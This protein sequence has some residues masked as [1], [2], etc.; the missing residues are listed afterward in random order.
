MRQ[1]IEQNEILFIGT[2]VF[3][4]IPIQSSEWMFQQNRA[5][6]GITVI[7]QMMKTGIVDINSFRMAKDPAL[8]NRS[9]LSKFIAFP[10]PYLSDLAHN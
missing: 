10:S 7:H 9:H 8:S 1:P 3:E 4:K 2:S 5:I 6:F